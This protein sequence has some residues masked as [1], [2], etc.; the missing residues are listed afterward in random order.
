M[1]YKIYFFQ[2]SLSDNR[3]DAARND[4]LAKEYSVQIKELRQQLTDKRFEKIS[5]RRDVTQTDGD[6]YLSI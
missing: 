4:A 1:V 5:S 2:T 3:A 6:R